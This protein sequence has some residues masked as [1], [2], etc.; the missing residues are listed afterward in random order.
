M[1]FRLRVFQKGLIL[2]GVPF[3]LELLLLGNLSILLYQSEQE[4]RNEV[5]YRR[6]S[7]ITAKL[8]CTMVQIPLFL[9]ASMETKSD[10]LFEYYEKNI[11]FLKHYTKEAIALSKRNLDLTVDCTQDLRQGQKRILDIAAKV[12]SKRKGNTITRLDSLVNLQKSLSHVTN[13]YSDR[14]HEILQQGE[15]QITRSRLHQEQIRK[16]QSR[17]LLIGAV[18]NILIGI[19]LAIFYRQSILKRIGVITKNTIALYRGGLMSEPLGGDDE[20]ALVDRAF[21]KMHDDLNAASQRERDLF[22]KASDVICVLSESNEFLKVN[23]IC[24]QIWDFEPEDL[25]EK[26]LSILLDQ[27]ESKL[28]ESKLNTAKASDEAIVFDCRINCKHSLQKFMRWSIYWSKT[29][30]CLFC[31]VHDIS[32]QKKLEKA[33]AGFQKMIASQLAAPLDSISS[34]FE[35]LLR[36]KSNKLPG[37]ASKKLE[38]SSGNL[39]RLLELVKELL[40]LSKTDF[41]GENNRKVKCD[42]HELISQAKNDIEEL[43]R[44]KSISINLEKVE[45]TECFVDR[46][47]LIQVFVNLLSNAIKFSPEHSAIRISSK[48]RKNILVCKVLDQGRGVPE[49]RRQDIFD[50]YSQ[51]QLSDAKRQSGTGL[52]LPICKQIIEDHGGKISLLCPADGG[53]CFVIQLPQNEEGRTEKLTVEDFATVEMPAY[54]MPTDKMS[55][56][57]KPEKKFS[58]HSSP[59]SLPVKGIFLIGIPIACEI[60]IVLSLS[61]ILLEVDKERAN[62]LHQRLVTNAANNFS[63][64]A[65]DTQTR[66]GH[67]YTDAEWQIIYKDIENARKTKVLLQ[68]LIADD[69]RELALFEKASESIAN[70]EEN[71]DLAIENASSKEG[72]YLQFADRYRMFPSMLWLF[73]N[74]QKIM[75]IAESKEMKSPAKQEE[76]RQKEAQILLMGLAANLISSLA[77]AIFFSRDINSRLM[78]LADNANRLSMSKALNPPLE[79]VDEIAILDRELHTAAQAL[80]E[81]RKKEQNIFDNSQDIVCVLDQ[82]G[83]FLSVNPSCQK[84]FGL[85]KAEILEKT[86]TELAIPEDREIAERAIGNQNQEQEERAKLELRIYAA[87]SKAEEHEN[88]ST[89]GIVHTLWSLARNPNNPLIYCIAHDI[90]ARKELESIKQEFLAMVSHDLRSPLAAIQGSVQLAA[91][92]S[93]GEIEAASLEILHELDRQCRN[94]IELISDLLDF[95]KLDAGKMPLN[96][97]EIEL[98]EVLENVLAGARKRDYTKLEYSLELDDTVVEID[99]DRVERAISSIL[100]F[101]AARSSRP[102]RMKLARKNSMAEIQIYDSSN[103]LAENDKEKFFDIF[104]GEAECEVGAEVEVNDD[105]EGALPDSKLRLALANKVFEMHGGSISINTHKQGNLYCLYLPRISD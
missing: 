50:K 36:E 15:K 103:F 14:L 89:G 65:V 39:Q 91:R 34:G 58:A 85:E 25:L 95:E 46:N 94:L 98:V 63:I 31:I 3:L 47:R 7:M 26:T 18:A 20:I 2:V 21:H 30:N 60:A 40:K 24:K 62:E 45:K 13:Q 69:P 92:G 11:E 76:L 61:Q 86:L 74:M 6:G 66:L 87:G 57:I 90:S 73:R 51:S 44:Q 16:A 52:G 56:D 4:R 12:A 5:V 75:E 37:E 79:G 8:I 48:V 96:L 64:S 80:S 49:E 27:E 10:K 105:E 42:I 78:L 67:E 19:L 17:I 100:D 101:A 104:A 70:L 84:V 88:S 72:P 23:P 93:Y 35:K 33:K 55:A 59:F 22:E 99:R 9:A 82:R 54:K 38:I 29:E 41:V 53:S 77:L 32:E 28:F 43:A 1:P 97:T 102:L 83:K 71:F 68:K 81:A